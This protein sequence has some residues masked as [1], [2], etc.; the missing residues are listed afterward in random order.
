MLLKL[1]KEI[2]INMKLF[3]AIIGGLALAVAG[4]SLLF[5]ARYRILF[6]GEAIAGMVMAG[7]LEVKLAMTSFYIVIGKEFHEC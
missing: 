4:T 7:V 5:G 6:A 3:T 2:C 1:K